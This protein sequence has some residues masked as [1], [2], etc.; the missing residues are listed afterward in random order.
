MLLQRLPQLVEQSAILDGDD[1]LA[2]EVRD[3]LDL[4]FGEGPHLSAPHGDDADQVRLP[5]QRDGQHRAGA[6]VLEDHGREPRLH[7]DIRDVDRAA[8]QSGQP[9]RSCPP[10]HELNTHEFLSEFRRGVVVR[11]A[12][13]KLAIVSPERREVALTQA[14]RVSKDGIEY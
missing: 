6:L 11:R 5:Q 4:L 9:R 14:R 13:E 2:R 7:A 1:G 8:L 3:Q 12:H 10:G